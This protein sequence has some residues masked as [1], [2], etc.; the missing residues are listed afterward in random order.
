MP[1]K[2]KNVE[3]LTA[4]IVSSET[5]YNGFFKVRILEIKHDQF[6]TDKPMIIKREVFERGNAVAV[7]V[8][9]PVLDKVLL[10]REMRVGALAAY[11]AGHKNLKSSSDA[12]VYA[13][14]AG[15]IEGINKETGLPHDEYST[16]LK[17]VKEETGV[18]IKKENLIGP[19]PT[20]PSPGGCSE[21]V[22][23]F[24]AIGDLSKVSAINGLKS[25]GENIKSEV[26]DFN[27]A[28]NIVKN[29]TTVVTTMSSLMFQLE[30]LRNELIYDPAN[31]PQKEQLTKNNLLKYWEHKY[32]EI[33]GVDLNSL[34]DLLTDKKIIPKVTPD[35]IE[36]IENN[37][38]L[39]S[40]LKYK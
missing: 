24:I 30:S 13:T 1:K 14:P 10:S 11:E 25:E 26:L 19:I 22:H 34:A 40:K 31:V 4:K 33:E 12:W 2:I 37:Y 6:E 28:L 17:E 15:M 20:M 7:L 8:Y 38:L 16:A 32:G 39:N 29:G 5:K 9:D 21:F 36:K 3:E 35:V 18:K 27:E 23:L